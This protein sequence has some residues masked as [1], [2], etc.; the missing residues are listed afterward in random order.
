MEFEEVSWE[1][2]ERE[3]LVDGI[4]ELLTYERERVESEERALAFV[5]AQNEK[6]RFEQAAR[7]YEWE[8]KVIER[9]RAE[10]FAQRIA[11]ERARARQ[12]ARAERANDE[13]QLRQQLQVV[14]IENALEREVARGRVEQK[15]RVWRNAAQ[16]MLAA[17]AIA[18]A[19]GGYSW[20]SAQTNSRTEL[21]ELRQD[22]E[23]TRLSAERRVAELEAELAR[24]SDGQGQGRDLLEEQLEVAR[25]GLIAAQGESEELERKREQR[26]TTPPRRLAKST[27]TV[28]SNEKKGDPATQAQG[29]VKVATDAAV[30]QTCLAYDP[31]CFEL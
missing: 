31:M 10:R 15:R 7:A 22:A 13:V 20:K 5:E 25:A 9:Q 14:Q 27:T 18:A 28:P 30:E 21:T 26:D 8:Q 29:G 1:H 19:F 23:N 11:E 6:R 12:V 24:A 16:G 17:A 4:N 2:L 3:S